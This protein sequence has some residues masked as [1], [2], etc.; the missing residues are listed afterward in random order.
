MAAVLGAASYGLRLA[1]TVEHKMIG[2]QKSGCHQP[3][4]ETVPNY[5][6]GGPNE[7]C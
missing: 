1:V 7:N 3:K 4:E 5:L 2:I 6:G